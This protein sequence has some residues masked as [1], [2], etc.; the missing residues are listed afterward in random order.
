MKIPGVSYVYILESK[1]YRRAAKIGKANTPSG[2][3]QDIATSIR[4]ETGRDANMSLFFC[5]PCRNPRKIET[6]I[7]HM[8]LYPTYE[9]DGS[10]RTEWRHVGIK[11]L[12]IKIP[13]VANPALFCLVIIAGYFA[14]LSSDWLCFAGGCALVYPK[15][16]DFA[17]YVVILS[18]IDWLPVAGVIWMAY[19]ILT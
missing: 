5:F 6:A 19:K 16:F 7:H 8:K 15:P 13:F 14:G 10:G 4:K 17:I 18:L 11:L 2:R 3:M 1:L 12:G 9:A